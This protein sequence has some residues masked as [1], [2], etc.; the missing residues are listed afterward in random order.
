MKRNAAHDVTQRCSE[1]DGQKNTCQSEDGVEE[2]LPQLVV[3]VR[4]ELNADAA[5]HEEPQH[6]RQRQIKAAEAGGVEQRKCEVQRSTGGE[7]PNLV[8]VPYRADG[9]QDGTAL[10][11]VPGDEEMDRAGSEIK[12][13][14]Q[15]INRDHYRDDHEP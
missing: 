7:Q 1:E 15:N 3:D 11:V 4:A 14:Q 13:V 2:T 10:L 5:Q 8:A 9:T 6:H 12:A